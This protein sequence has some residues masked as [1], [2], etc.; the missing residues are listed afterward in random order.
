MKNFLVVMLYLFSIFKLNK[1]KAGLLR[2]SK[3]F[4][5]YGKGGYYHPQWLPSHPELIIIGNNV[6]IAADVRF[7]EHDLIN[8]MYICDP[9][10]I[11]P[12]L[13]YYTG[14]IT[15]SDNV[16]IGARSIVLYNVKIGRNALIA[17]GSVCTKDVPPYAIVAGN[18]AKV[19]GSTKDLLKKRFEYSGVDIEGFE[20]ELAFKDL[21]RQ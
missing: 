7:Y 20:Y 13:K 2:K 12:D 6:T 19:I 17:A 10:Y 14:P 15:I 16:V 3:I 18:P 8:R 21:K 5:E 11:G 4:K 1:K 9:N